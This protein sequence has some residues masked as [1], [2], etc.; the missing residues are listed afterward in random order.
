[1]TRLK[2]T[3]SAP[4]F[5]NAA[6]DLSADPALRKA[7]VS[8]LG[9]L[10][11]TNSVPA[12]AALL[13]APASGPA[14]S[15]EASGLRLAAIESLGHIGGDAALAALRTALQAVSLDD[16][17]AAI[18]AL[19][20][21]RDPVA[22]PDLIAG[23]QSADTR[24][25]ALTALARFSDLRALD[26]Y[27]EGL[28]SAD[29]TV[30][31]QCRKALGPI[32]AEALPQIERRAPSLSSQAV[33]ELRRVYSDDKTALERPLFL[34]ASPVPDV[35]EYER[36]AL[37]QSG[38]AARGQRV[39]FDEGGVA[40]IRCHT[41]AGIGGTVGPDLTLAGAQFSRAQLIE[42]ILYP[43]RA[44]R[45]GYQQIIIET[46]LGEEVSGVLKADTADG[47]ML[48][49]A[50]GRTHFVPR[51]SIANRRGSELS[52]MPEGLHAGLTM[53][54]FADLIAYVESRK[55]DPRLPVAEPPPAG[56]KPLFNGVDLTGWR[57]YPEQPKRVGE[58]AL[59]SL[60]GGRP[61]GGAGE[62]KRPEGRAPQHWLARDGVLEH[63]GKAADLW[64]E[65]EFADFTLR[66]D[67][68][69]PEAPKWEHFPIIGPDS[70]EAKGPDGKPQTERVLDAGDSGVF[71]RGLR[72]AQANLFCYP[73]GS[74]EVWEYRTDLTLPE[75]VRRGVTPK[76]CADA[77][78]GDWNRMEITV[79]A[80]LL[81]VVLNG[82]EAISGARL[83]GLPPRGP[84]GFQHEHGRIQLRNICVVERSR[85][86]N[87]KQRP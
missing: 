9:E 15:P 48:V 22:V 68:R 64:T 11:D 61:A 46:K 13:G 56:F 82:H 47:V 59:R 36:H 77:P 60:Q 72:K 26:A 6:Q 52:L 33:A 5:A 16:R 25:E 51:A 49:D 14:G 29:P 73:V 23:W 74:G 55:V 58:T 40:C 19:G 41:V 34:A 70:T 12:L 87:P 79:R 44:V 69:W 85:L 65:G 18:R 62:M 28:A 31:E 35:A 76:R 45:E 10:R 50:S 57:E 66:F 7:A 78:V 54:Q 20:S 30:R 80:D 81:T 3:N 4:L 53:N 17:R 86:P 24:A 2:D 38:D 39:Y 67:W 1:M 71:L 42:S 83:P 27:L 21:L 84:I 75:E 32:R 8:A 37:A 43:G 63:D